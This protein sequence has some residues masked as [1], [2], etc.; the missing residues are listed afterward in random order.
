M[1]D[2]FLAFF[3]IFHFSMRD[4]SILSRIFLPHIINVIE[5]F[6]IFQNCVNKFFYLFWVLNFSVASEFYFTGKGYI[7]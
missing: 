6:L 5:L 2:F 7:H 3:Y 1:D 4:I